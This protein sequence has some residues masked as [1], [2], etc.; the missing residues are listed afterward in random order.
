[1]A[2][3]G[4]VDEV[5]QF[6]DVIVAE[7]TAAAIASEAETAGGPSGS[8]RAHPAVAGGC[9]AAEPERR[10][11]EARGTHLGETAVLTSG[12]GRAERRRKRKAGALRVI[13]HLLLTRIDAAVII[14]R[15][16]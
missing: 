12:P 1:M 10:H 14:W 2:L 9:F 13:L 8:G 5:M 16:T 15:A 4:V 11:L 6:Q 3:T 7:E